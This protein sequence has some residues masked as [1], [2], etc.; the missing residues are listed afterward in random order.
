[1][2]FFTVVV[3]GL[4]RRRT[5]TI[6]TLLGISIG[7]AAV[8][9]LVGLS[10]GLNKSWA[11]GMKARG[12]D[13]VVS[14]MTSSLVPKPF[15]ATVR[16]RIAHLPH[17]AATC[18][19][20]VDLM[21]VENTE[22][23]MVSGRE[24]SG[25]DWGNLK[26]ITGRMPN[27]A[28]EKA[29]VLGRT[30]ADVLKKK[31]GDPIQIET[32][33]LKVVGIVDGN[34]WVE[35]GS[36]I[37]SLP[38]LQEI[39]GDQDRINVIDVRLT[40]GTSRADVQQLCNQINQLIPE[41]RAIVASENLNQSEISRI[42]GAMS[43]S[44]SLLAVLVGVLGVT[45]TMLMNVFERTPEICVLLALGWKRRRIVELI[46]WE[47]AILGLLGGIIG[48]FIGVVGVRL[49]GATPSI[50]GLLEPDIGIRL[51]AVSVAIAIVVGVASG[52]YPAWRSSRVTPSQALHG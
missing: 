3:R 31:V 19:L 39:T 13:V 33:E 42:V 34:A 23:I 35:N 7:I 10:R 41:A 2:S 49:L 11:V 22:M 6:L 36:V 48:V 5:R 8:V 20:L 4:T 21:S 29:V 45:N 44:T 43:W 50:R 52:L 14:N 24:W 15:N 1:M 47:S 46:L 9:A 18:A 37:L 51:L 26:L 28:H 27:D 12:T 25:F 30:A 38:L 17:I 40:P 16:D 32:A